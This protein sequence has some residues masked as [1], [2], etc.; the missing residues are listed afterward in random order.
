MDKKWLLCAVTVCTVWDDLALWLAALT[1][2]S[3]TQQQSWVQTL[4]PLN[5]SAEYSTKNYA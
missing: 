5:S 2:N 3:F 1:V 4:Y